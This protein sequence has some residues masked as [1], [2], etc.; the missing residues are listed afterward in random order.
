MIHT[1]LTQ[2]PSGAASPGRRAAVALRRSAKRALVL[3]AAGVLASGALGSAPL[4]GQSVAAAELATG[5]DLGTPGAPVMIGLDVTWFQPPVPFVA[6][7][8]G[9]D[10]GVASVFSDSVPAAAETAGFR[11]WAADLDFVLSPDHAGRSGAPAGALDP[12]LFAGA[13]LRGAMN[14]AGETSPVVT[15]SYGGAISYWLHPNV[16]VDAEGRRWM[17]VTGRDGLAARFQPDGWSFRLG[18]ALHLGVRF[19]GEAPA[20]GLPR[21]DTVWLEPEADTGG[22]GVT[23]GAGVTGGPEAV[24]PPPG[25]DRLAPWRRMAVDETRAEI[26]DEAEQ[27]LGTPYVWGG[28]EPESGFDCSGFVQYVFQTHGIRLPRPSRVMAQAGRELPTVVDSLLPG[29]V[30]FFSRT[31]SEDN[32]TH[33]G[34]YAG[35][36]TI[37]HATGSGGGV[38][39][40]DLESP[41][42]QWFADRFVA[43]SRVIGVPVMATRSQVPITP[44]TWD[45]KWD[46]A[47]PKP[48]VEV[49]EDVEASEGG[50]PESGGESG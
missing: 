5:V 37:L 4:T 34:I 43:A 42:G 3:A 13:G 9:G 1:P 50:T 14:D 46:G 39:Y 15:A 33:V 32:I 8:I 19:T 6:A 29:D 31:G 48:G 49:P 26:L 20:A 44:E 30:L 47:P 12:L 40:D 7:R 45:P 2:T 35:D 22:T 16:R 25:L 38:A 11:A 21:V 36:R 41:R 27:L 23:G 10:L 24:R 28:A 18:V 17:A